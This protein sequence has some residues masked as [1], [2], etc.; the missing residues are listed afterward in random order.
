M[1]DPF[2]INN[3]A[4]KVFLLRVL[5]EA[6]ARLVLRLIIIERGGNRD[7]EEKTTISMELKMIGDAVLKL[8]MSMADDPPNP[9]IDYLVLYVGPK[10][11]KQ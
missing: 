8:M 11:D 6:Q 2:V 1:S 10:G 9:V 3:K 7:I 4:E 5:R